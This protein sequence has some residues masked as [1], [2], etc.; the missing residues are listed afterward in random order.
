MQQ[1]TTTLIYSIQRQE[2]INIIERNQ[3]I[4]F[5]KWKSIVILELI[6]YWYF[7]LLM[8]RTKKNYK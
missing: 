4:Q 1:Y 3:S 2:S 6:H 5:D 8:T 7:C